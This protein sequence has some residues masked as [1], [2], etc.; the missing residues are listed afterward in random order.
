[1]ADGPS[2]KLITLEGVEGAGKSTQV[3][4]IKAAI[5]ALGHSVLVTRE[6]GG[7]TL[8][9]AIRGLLLDGGSMPEMTELLLMFAARHSHCAEKI[10][11]AL[12]A[13]EWVIC[14][15]FVDASYAYQG[16]GRGIEDVHIKALEDMVLRGREPDLVLVFDLPVEL[17]LVRTQ[18]RG[19]ENRFEREDVAF[20]NRVREA[21]LRRARTEP[22]RY[23]VVDASQ[24]EA[25]VSTTVHASIIEKFKQHGH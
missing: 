1:M 5:E 11:P 8:A 2:G 15:R 13:G 20:M 17:G 16:A 7:T 23:I 12:A 22:H 10:E 18:K 6:P 4:T 24:D 14:D 21:Y 9:E 3:S 25:S 19:D